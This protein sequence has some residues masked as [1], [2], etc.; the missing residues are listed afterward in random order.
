MGSRA[1]SVIHSVVFLLL[2]LALVAGARSV[3]ASS[4]LPDDAVS[5]SKGQEQLSV[6][7]RPLADEHLTSGVTKEGNI[8]GQGARVYYT[9]D[10]PGGATALDVVLDGPA[11]ADFDLYVRRGQRPTGNQYD[12][13]GYTASADEAV[14]I[15]NPTAGTYHIL[16]YGYRGA[17]R[18]Q[19]TATV[20]GG[21]EPETLTSGVPRD[22]NISSQGARVYYTIVVP[23]GATRWT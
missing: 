21:G 10:V 22:G 7:L 6:R 17:G 20:I 13:R 15:D 19:L 5:L 11:G 4:S 16:V 3:F 23:S 18:F 1:G 2:L 8:T 12:G 14:R 9:I